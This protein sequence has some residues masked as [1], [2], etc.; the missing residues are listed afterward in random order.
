MTNVWKAL[1]VTGTLIVGSVSGTVFDLLGR[2][3]ASAAMS[4]DLDAVLAKTASTLNARLPMMVDKDTRLDSTIPGPGKNFT[5]VYTL[6]AY[7]SAELD[8]ATTMA[9]VTPYVKGNTCGLTDMKGFFKNGIS[10]I[11]LY[12][13]NDGREIGRVTV[14]PADCL[15]NTRGR[16]EPAQARQRDAIDRFLD[17]ETPGLPAAR[18]PETR[19][20]G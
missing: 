7:R 4:P 17:G 13:G 19:I 5:Y 14:S 18:A 8:P 15:E 6:P 1:V 9:A 20:G 2:D 11:Y 3:L 10:V 12:R 16:A